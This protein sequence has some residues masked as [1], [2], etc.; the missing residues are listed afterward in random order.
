MMFLVNIYRKWDELMTIRGKR[1]REKGR[2]NWEKGEKRTEERKV[3]GRGRDKEEVG[4][5]Y[6]L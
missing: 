3:R 4:V 5:N 6:T 1:G 2:R